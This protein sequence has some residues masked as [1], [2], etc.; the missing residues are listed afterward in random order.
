MG[1]SN[2]DDLSFSIQGLRSPDYLHS[3]L[4]P[5]SANHRTNPPIVKM[6]DDNKGHEKSYAKD[7]ADLPKGQTDRHRTCAQ[8]PHEKVLFDGLGARF[9]GRSSPEEDV[10]IIQRATSSNGPKLESYPI[11]SCRHPSIDRSICHSRSFSDALNHERDVNHS[12]KRTL[13]WLLLQQGY[14]YE[15]RSTKE[16][17]N[18]KDIFKHLQDCG[19][20]VKEQSDNKSRYTESRLGDLYAGRE[21][22]SGLSAVGAWAE[23]EPMRRSR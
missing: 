17:N 19:L 12:Q 23:D 21:N 5:A 16:C 2:I 8:T 10:D 15:N 14:G 22:V 1:A 20:D 7:R 3:R 9:G 18:V 11:S 4:A 13:D 6:P